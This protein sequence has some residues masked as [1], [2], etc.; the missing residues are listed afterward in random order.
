MAG[1]DDG[2][3]SG[4]TARA[5]P[6]CQ[7]ASAQCR[8][9]DRTPFMTSGGV[10]RRRFRGGG[11]T[12]RSSSRRQWRTGATQTTGSHGRGRFMPCHAAAAGRAQPLRA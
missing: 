10:S 5:R 8:C 11:A 3:G 9:S 2:G 1:G 12:T 6:H 7:R 4:G